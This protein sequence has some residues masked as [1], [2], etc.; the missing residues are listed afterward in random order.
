MSSWRFLN[1]SGVN[2]FGFGGLAFGGD[3]RALVAT[4]FFERDEAAFL[5]RSEAA[6]F[7]RDEV[8]VVARR[9]LRVEL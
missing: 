6:F 5:L 4:V 8:D 9:F 3:L 1:S 7:V 2:F